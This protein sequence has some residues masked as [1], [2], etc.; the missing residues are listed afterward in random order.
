MST[1]EIIKDINRIVTEISIGL[2]DLKAHVTNNNEQKEHSGKK[3][4]LAI[5]EIKDFISQK[6]EYKEGAGY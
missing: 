2:D 3:I 1:L 4:R 6:V 5:E